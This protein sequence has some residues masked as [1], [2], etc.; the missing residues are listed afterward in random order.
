[1]DTNDTT[2]PDLVVIDAELPQDDTQSFGSEVTKTLLVSTAMSALVFGGAAVI[3]IAGPK[4]VAWFSRK[5]NNGVIIEGEVGT[6]TDAAPA[7]N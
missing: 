3:T 4:V 1:M 7:E 6:V 2:S 5:K